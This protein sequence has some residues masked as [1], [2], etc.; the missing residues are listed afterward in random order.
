MITLMITLFIAVCNGSCNSPLCDQSLI[1]G[2][3]EPQLQFPP[4]PYDYPYED[5]DESDAQTV[6]ECQECSLSYDSGNIYGSSSSELYY[7][8][9]I[10]NTS[11]PSHFSLSKKGLL[12][13]DYSCNWNY[14]DMDFNKLR[15]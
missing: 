7:P 14:L 3:R 4:P 5:P 9:P 12:Q 11:P 8:Q 1:Y 13:I 6:M 2:V 10:Y 15:L